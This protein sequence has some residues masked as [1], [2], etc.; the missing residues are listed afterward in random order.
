MYHHVP[1]KLNV[2]EFELAV[3]HSSKSQAQELICYVV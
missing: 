2:S 1:V 3:K